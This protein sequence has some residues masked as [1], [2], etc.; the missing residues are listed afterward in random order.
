MLWRD[1]AEGPRLGAAAMDALCPQ[2]TV[3]VRRDSGDNKIDR[4]ERKGKK[5]SVMWVIK[6]RGGRKS[7]FFP[8]TYGK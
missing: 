5:T 3:A 8:P 7:S 2:V 6:R 4:R 1:A